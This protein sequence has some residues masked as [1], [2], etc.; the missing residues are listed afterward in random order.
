M[1]RSSS[2]L[3]TVHGQGSQI[4][5]AQPQ[6]ALRGRARPGPLVAGRPVVGSGNRLFRR[7]PSGDARSDHVC[8][9]VLS[10]LAV[11]PQ[12]ATLITYRQRQLSAAGLA[13]GLGES[14]GD[15]LWSHPT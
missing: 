6:T 9:D 7:L 10:R 1:I 8:R 4:W 12:N 2:V 11:P 15:G 5:T 3:R 14:A 13:G